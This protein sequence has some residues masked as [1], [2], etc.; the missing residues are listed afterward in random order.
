MVSTVPIRSTNLA[1]SQENQGG[2]STRE[3][4]ESSGGV[5]VPPSVLV[6]LDSNGILQEPFIDQLVILVAGGVGEKDELIQLWSP[7]V[8]R[9]IKLP[10]N[11][12][13]LLQ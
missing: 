11:W 7:P 2:G 9:E 3:Q 6:T 4:F 8:S 12:N 13:D 10:P 5:A 1:S